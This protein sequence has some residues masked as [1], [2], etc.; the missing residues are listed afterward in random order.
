[1]HKKTNLSFLLQASTYS[2]L[3]KDSNY[4]IPSQQK[5]YLGS[6]LEKLRRSIPLKI[7]EQG[8]WWHA[9][10]K[11][12]HPRIIR[13]FNKGLD[14]YKGEAILRVG[15]RWCYVEVDQTPFLIL[16][17]YP[18]T[19]PV[20]STQTTLWALL[21][22]QE[23]YPLNQLSVQEQIIYAQLTSDRFA[24]FSRHAQS[25]CI[26]WLQQKPNLSSQDT[27]PTFQLSYHS[28]TWDIKEN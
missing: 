17:L 5:I 18:Q 9:G 16:K 28:K 4:L 12:M 8:N 14:W 3:I 23:T 21:N 11:I 22:T 2:N 13:L 7:D 27:C 26:E 20:D 15:Q 6:D 24:R 19:D 1:M 25:Q 10:E